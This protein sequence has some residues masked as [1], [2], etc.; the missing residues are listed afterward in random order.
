MAGRSPRRLRP[1][2]GRRPGYWRG[3]SF[4]LLVAT[5][6]AAAE[7]RLYAARAN[8]SGAGCLPAICGK[9]G[10]FNQLENLLAMTAVG[11]VLISL[12]SSIWRTQG[13]L[14][15]AEAREHAIHP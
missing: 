10:R 2:P 7:E 5:R 6:Y 8:I 13:N 4:E 15:V 14:T 12:P 9:L 3:A 11:L 1:L